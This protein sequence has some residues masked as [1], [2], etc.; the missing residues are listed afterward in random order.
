MA[1]FKAGDKVRCI[2]KSSGSDGSLTYGGGGWAKDKIFIVNST[3]NAG[4][5]YICWPKSG[6][7][8]VWEHHL[9][10]VTLDWDE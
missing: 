7:S 6:G 2:G 4:L 3:T 1:K 10:L 8:G 9:E 5:Y